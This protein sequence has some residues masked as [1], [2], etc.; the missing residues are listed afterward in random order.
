[1][2]SPLAGIAGCCAQPQAA[3]PPRR[4]ASQ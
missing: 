4:Q 1:L 2:K 3:K